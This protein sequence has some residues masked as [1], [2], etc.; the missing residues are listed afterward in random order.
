[1][2]KLYRPAPCEGLLGSLSPYAHKIELWLRMAGIPY[3]EEILSAVE[4]L[5]S[6]PRGLF[7]YVDL[8]GERI[9]DSTIIV[10]RLRDL[11]NDPL[12]D[13]RLTRAQQVQGELIQS[14]CDHELNFIM[15]YGRFGDEDSDYKTLCRFNVG[16]YVPAEQLEERA[17]AYRAGAKKTLHYWRIG[18]YDSEY[19]NNQLRKCL[20]MLSYILGEQPWLFDEAP[21]THDVGLCAHLSSLIY[22][23]FRNPQTAVANE[24][25]NLVEY[26][27][28]IRAAYYD[29][30]TNISS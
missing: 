22:F 10:D 16:D 6:A 28:R 20:G 29:Y 27:D 8:D 30:D 24:Y 1:M 5:A 12:N 21:S 25:T 9:D 7:P 11:H 4:L 17:E 23:P 19:V 15:A 14:L 18:R 3:E 2:L 26:C 13:G